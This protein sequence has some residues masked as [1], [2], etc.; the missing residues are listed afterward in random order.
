MFSERVAVPTWC[1][2]V[3]YRGDGFCVALHTEWETKTEGEEEGEKEKG[4]GGAFT[5]LTNTLRVVLLWFAN[6]VVV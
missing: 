4:R 3:R 1:V 6:A 2:C 5:A